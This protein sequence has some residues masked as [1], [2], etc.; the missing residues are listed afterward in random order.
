MELSAT[1]HYTCLSLGILFIIGTLTFCDHREQNFSPSW[2]S[3][4]FWGSQNITSLPL[5]RTKDE[6]FAFRLSMP[7]VTDLN[8]H[9]LHQ[10]SKLLR[11]KR[12][13]SQTQPILFFEFVNGKVIVFR[14]QL[15][16]CCSCILLFYFVS[17]A[18]CV[19]CAVCPRY[20]LHKS[21]TLLKHCGGSPKWLEAQSLQG[22]LQ[23]SFRRIER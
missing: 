1:F 11:R 20:S 9:K 3:E 2:W 4:E 8:S 10:T 19:M 12:T 22:T 5:P 7:K 18:K 6:T 13:R 23:Q 17:Y 14:A 15:A 21:N 16:K